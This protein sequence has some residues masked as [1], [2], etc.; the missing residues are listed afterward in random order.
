MDAGMPSQAIT[1]WLAAR[2]YGWT[3]NNILLNLCQAYAKVG[4]YDKAIIHGIEGLRDCPLNKRKEL[5]D[6]LN[7]L[8]EK[9]R[10]MDQNKKMFKRINES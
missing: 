2:N 8:Q 10:K 4:D 1:H 5:E 3:N 9:K 6:L 7:I